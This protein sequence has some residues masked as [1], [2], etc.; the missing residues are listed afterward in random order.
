MKIS[1][2]L[3]S[4]V[5]GMISNKKGIPDWLSQEYGDGFMKICRHTKAVIMGKKTYD[6]LVPDYLPLKSNS[7]GTMIVLTHGVSTNPPQPNV[8]FTDKNP[9]DIVNMLE[10][11][12]HSEALLLAER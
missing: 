3:A 8:I 12:G 4:S 6:I 5:N 1:I 11:R 10:E 9:Q 2:Y 7:E